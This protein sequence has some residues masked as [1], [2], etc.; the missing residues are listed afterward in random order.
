MVEYG[1]GQ[2]HVIPEIISIKKLL[3]TYQLVQYRLHLSEISILNTL[4][5]QI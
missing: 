1:F 4:F 2:E 5:N 3:Y